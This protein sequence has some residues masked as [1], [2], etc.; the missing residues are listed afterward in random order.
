MTV[1]DNMKSGGM[2]EYVRCSFDLPFKAI[3]FG[4]DCFI[5]HG[6]PQR[7]YDEYEMS[8]EKIAHKIIKECRGIAE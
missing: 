3:N 7:L 2:G 5:P 6:S 8:P 1:E 4:Y